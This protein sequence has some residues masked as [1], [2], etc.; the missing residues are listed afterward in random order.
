MRGVSD[1]VECPGSGSCRP[2][3]GEWPPAGWFGRRSTRSMSRCWP[4]RP[5]SRRSL[6]AVESTGH[7]RSTSAAW[8]SR[9]RNAAGGRD[10]EILGADVAAVPTARPRRRDAR[11]RVS[12]PAG[13]GEGVL[14]GPNVTKQ[15]QGLLRHPGLLKRRF[16]VLRRRVRVCCSRLTTNT[17]AHVPPTYPPDRREA[18][19]HMGTLLAKGRRK[20]GT[21]AIGAHD[22]STAGADPNS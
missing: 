10:L 7:E 22:R 14:D 18:A 1:P 8:P 20:G 9:G 6:S 17:C 21:A 19:A 5:P 12:G 11:P 3:Q 2:A 13:A 16:H 4:S 15:S